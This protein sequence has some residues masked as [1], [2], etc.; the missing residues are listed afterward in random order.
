MEERA[1]RSWHRNKLKAL[2]L[3]VSLMAFEDFFEDF[4]AGL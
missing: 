3:F 4:E 1:G 2:F